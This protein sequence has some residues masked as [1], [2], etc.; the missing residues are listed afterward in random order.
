MSRKRRRSKERPELQ[1]DARLQESMLRVGARD[2]MF[3][4]HALARL[5]EAHNLTPEQQAEALGI[6]P[7]ALALLSLCKMPRADQRD[8]DVA[9]VAKHLG[10]TI[11]VLERLLSEVE[12]LGPETA[13]SSG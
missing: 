1:V 11:E 10:I 4:G 5:R 9:A 2:P 12:R 13:P 6:T 8:A 7:S 3:F